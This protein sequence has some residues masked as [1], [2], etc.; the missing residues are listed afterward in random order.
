MN[1]RHKKGIYKPLLVTG[2]PRSGTSWYVNHLNGRYGLKMGHEYVGEDGAVSGFFFGDFD[3]YPYKHGLMGQKREDYLF[4]EV[5]L[6]VRNPLNTIPSLAILLSRP[7]SPARHFYATNLNVDD[8]DPTLFAA[9][10]WVRS[11][12]YILDNEHL[13]DIIL[14]EDEWAKYPKEDSPNKSFKSQYKEPLTLEDLDTMDSDLA[15]EV[16]DLMC[17]FGYEDSDRCQTLE[18]KDAKNTENKQSIL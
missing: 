8:P 18:I 2:C 9:R 16:L 11:Q 10:A 7:N 5:H 13:D 12:K 15:I 17:V 4:G 14:V 6:L 3:F 1:T